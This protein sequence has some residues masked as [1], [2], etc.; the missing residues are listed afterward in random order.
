MFF[1]NIYK[2]QQNRT[3]LFETTTS[4][5][6]IINVGLNLEITTKNNSIEITTGVKNLLSTQYIDHLS[7]FKTLEI[8]NQGINSI[9][10]LTQ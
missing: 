3:D 2:F 7:G 5:C 1:Q 4:D 9:F 8:P 10:N 6:N